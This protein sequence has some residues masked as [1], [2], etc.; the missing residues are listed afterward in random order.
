MIWR[1]IS[2]EADYDG[3][4]LAYIEKHEEC[5]AINYYQRTVENRSNRW[6]LNEGE[7][8]LYWMEL[9]PSP[10]EPTLVHHQINEQIKTT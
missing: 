8:L 1:P 3:T 10:T 4:Y 7:K 2:K 6:I 9:P 5:G